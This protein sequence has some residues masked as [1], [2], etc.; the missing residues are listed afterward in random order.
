M[1]PASRYS[2]FPPGLPLIP[3]VQVTAS[4]LAGTRSTLLGRPNPSRSTMSPQVLPYPS[5]SNCVAAIH[6]PNSI[7]SASGCATI[8]PG[9]SRSCGFVTS[10][11][12]PSSGRKQSI[13][14]EPTSSERNRRHAHTAECRSAESWVTGTAPMRPPVRCRAINSAADRERACCRPLRIRHASPI[15]DIYSLLPEGFA[16]IIGPFGQL[17]MS[18]Q[19][20]GRRHERGDVPAARLPPPCPGVPELSCRGH[21]ECSLEDRVPLRVRVV[22]PDHDDL[23]AR[24]VVQRPARADHPGGAGHLGSDPDLNKRTHQ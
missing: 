21:L 12:C 9:R 23:I 6:S 3:P 20:N 13:G 19:R 22:R 18:P 8:A 10:M 16:Q 24:R 7:K 11:S 1:V 14:V 15:R 4:M 2:I 5:R 17:P